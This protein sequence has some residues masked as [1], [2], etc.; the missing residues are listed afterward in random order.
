MDNSPIHFTPIRPAPKFLALAWTG[1]LLLVVS[2]GLS[3]CDR[4]SE[5]SSPAAS[6]SGDTA[7][8]RAGEGAP[9]SNV[10]VRTPTAPDTRGGGSSGFKG[11]P[12]I[13]DTSGGPSSGGNSPS[14][15]SS[16]PA[17]PSSATGHR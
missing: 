14:A 3:A 15:S 2:A 4:R 16:N 6:G 17:S 11:M 5:S 1:V 7:S 12:P 9:S 13:P 10:E 8:G